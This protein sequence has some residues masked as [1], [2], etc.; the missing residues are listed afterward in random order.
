MITSTFTY[1]HSLIC[2]L[3]WT[4]P[5]G[6]AGWC[7]DEPN[8]TCR[9]G[10]HSVLLRYSKY[11]NT[12]MLW[13][14]KCSVVSSFGRFWRFGYRVGVACGCV[15]SFHGVQDLWQDI[16]F[17]LINLQV[18]ERWR[19]KCAIPTLSMR[20]VVFYDSWRWNS[21]RSDH[22]WRLY[23]PLFVH[24]VPTPFLN[25]YSLSQTRVLTGVGWISTL[26]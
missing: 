20:W 24:F 21:M 18:R 15:I 19:C 13:A 16:W 10:Q 26:N 17:S 5:R 12:T 4:L 2:S 14:F 1:I 25:M 3:E 6:L 8:V 9:S 22:R 23:S 7:S 11:L